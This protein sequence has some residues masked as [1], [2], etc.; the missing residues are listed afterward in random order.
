[1]QNPPRRWAVV[2][3]MIW[4]T[5]HLL[6]FFVLMVQAFARP[7]ATSVSE[8]QHAAL[9]KIAEEVRNAVLANDHETLLSLYPE[10]AISNGGRE[11]LLRLLQ[12]E[13]AFNKASG[14]VVE[15]L[16]IAPTETTCNSSEFTLTFLTSTLVTRTRDKRAQSKGFYVALS[17]LHSQ[18][19]HLIDGRHLTKEQSQ[20]LFRELPV[21]MHSPTIQRTTL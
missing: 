20:K 10:M 11:R 4:S 2:V 3:A 17:P 8:E 7:I 6:T 14:L 21:E 12:T 19:W 15:S 16:D 13:D 1:M 5:G 18:Q 9:L